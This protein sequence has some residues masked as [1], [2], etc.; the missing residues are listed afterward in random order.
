MLRDYLSQD[1]FT[2]LI[3]V[4]LILVVVAR[5][6]SNSRFYDFIS[7]IWN[8][9]YL[10]LY[11]K[12][13]KKIDF[14][15]SILLINFMLSAGCFIYF[16]YKYFNQSTFNTTEFIPLLLLLSAIVVFVLAKNGLELLM[17]Y[18]FEISG[19]IRANLFQKTTYRNISGLILVV[20]NILLLF[21]NLDQKI[22]IYLAISVFFLINIS[23]FF[24]FLLLYQKLII[25]H[26]F[27]FLLYLCALE[28]GPYVILY[29]VLNDKIV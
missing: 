27:Y 29:K 10:K 11:T 1:F 7:V 24:R 5:Y 18:I 22:V 17:G 14:F 21:S 25:P 2:I 13:H 20:F 6:L 16:T 23:G 15:N 12:E 19:I 3:A 9:R 8:D 4:C 28:I 26:F